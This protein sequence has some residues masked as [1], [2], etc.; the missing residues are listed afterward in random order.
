MIERRANKTSEAAPTALE[1]PSPPTL[2]Q[3][4]SMAL[5][6]DLSS[7][8]LGELLTANDAAI[9][10]AEQAAQTAKEF[11]LD[12]T[13]SPDITTAHERMENTALLVGRL[14]TLRP[15]L[16]AKY[17]ETYLKEQAAE[18]RGVASELINEGNELADDLREVYAAS[19]G[20]LVDVFTRIAD[21]KK[22]RDACYSTRP[23]ALSDQLPDPELMARGLDG[24]TVSTPSLLEATKLFDLTGRQLWPDP[25]RTNP[26]RFAVEM[27]QSVLAM[28]S[29]GDPD[30]TGPNWWKAVARRQAAAAAEVELQGKRFAEMKIEQEKRE[31]EEAAAR[32]NA[33]HGT[34]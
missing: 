7:G 5:T 1:T 9:I 28:V 4:I 19:V 26:N 2:E 16:L 3:R 14:R 20:K 22:R 6:T 33:A 30:A 27:S 25:Q 31:N 12:P 21:Y 8:E 11:A 23:A 10:A 29:S 18:W 32:W 34:R 17:R 13:L 24:F 15:R